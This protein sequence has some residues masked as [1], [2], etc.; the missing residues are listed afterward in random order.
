MVFCD[1]EDESHLIDFDFVGKD[2][3]DVYPSTYNSRLAVRH[4]SANAHHPMKY[5]MYSRL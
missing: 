2:S 3:V 4:P 5:D 1:D